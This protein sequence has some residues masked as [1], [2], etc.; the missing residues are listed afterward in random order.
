MTHGPLKQY[1][2]KLAIVKDVILLKPTVML[3]AIL[4][5]IGFTVKYY[6]EF[7]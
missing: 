2:P 1:L 6:L 4:D 5:K 3:F 7:I